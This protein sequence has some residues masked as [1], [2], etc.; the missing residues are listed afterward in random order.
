MGRVPQW[1]RDGS[2]ARE[3][4]PL[5]DGAPGAGSRGR[6][7]FA[8]LTAMSLLAAGVSLPI[9]TLAQP[10][11]AAVTVGSNISVF[12]D[13]DM[14]VATGYEVGEQLL[15]EVVRDGVVIGTTQGPAVETA[16]GAG[17]EVNHGPLGAPQPGDCW[18][19]FTPDIIGGDVIRVTPVD[20]PDA[21][22]D[23]MTVQD[24]AFTGDPVLEADG[25]VSVSGTATPG[26]DFAVEFRRDKPAPR[27]RR[28]PFVPAFEAG[29]NKWKATFRPSTT[30]SPEGLTTTQQRDIA[31]N[32][33]SWLAVA[34][35]ITETTLAE[36][37]EPGGVGAGC[38]G[39]ADPNSLVGGLEP[40]NI[41]SGDVTFSGTAKAGV[42]AVSVTVGALGARDAALVTDPNGGPST[43]TLTV[44]K[45]DLA[46][47]P[48]GN[49]SVTPKFDTLVGAARTVVKDTIA[50][51]AP[52]VSVPPGTYGAPQSVVLNKPTGETTS[53]VY[54]EIGNTAVPDPDQFSNL[55]TTQISVTS[56]QTLKGRLIDAAGNPGAVGTFDYKIGTP[57]AAPAGLTATEST[58][59]AGTANLRWTA[60]AGAT[61]YNV[62]RDS[63]KVNT[64][65]LTGTSTTDKPGPGDYSYVVRAV[66][67][68]GIESLDSNAATVTIAAPDVPTGLRATEGDTRVTLNWTAVAGAAKYRIYRD[69][70][71]LASEPA[72]NSF[73]NTGLTNGTLYEYA[74]SALD[75]GGNESPRT[76]VVQAVPQVPADTTPPP[77]PAVNPATGTYT[78]AQ[79][80]TASNTE[81]GAVQRFTITAGTTPPAD[82]TSADEVVPTAGIPVSATSTV[83]V[84]SFDAAGN[85][86]TVITRTY[87]ITT[88]PPADTTPP[89]ASTVNPPTGTYT[90]TQTVTATNTEAGVT[91]RYT[92]GVGTTVP[93]D[94]TTASPALP[95]GGLA[96]S[97]SSVVKVAAFDAA[98]NKSVVTRTY[99]I[100]PA[101]GTTRTVNVV[102]EADAMVK[103]ASP[104]TAFGTPTTL[105]SDGQELSTTGSAVHSYLRFN[106]TG[107]A[108]GETITGARLQVRTILN[109]GGTPNGPIVRRAANAASVTAAESLTWTGSTPTANTSNVGNFA[110]VANDVVA[111]TAV[112][113][114]TGNG[115]VTL[116][117]APES[118]DGLLFLDRTA[119]AA[120]D[121]PQLILTVSGGT[122]PPADTTP[123]PAPSVNPAT[124]TYTSA[125]TVTATNTEAGVT[126]R[127][128]VGNG[129][130][131]PADPTTAST[132]LPAGGLT[133][134]TS[135]VV[136]VAAFDA[137]GNRSTV[138]QRGY[139]ISAP[140]AGGTRTL[141]V[142]ASADTTVRQA[143]PTGTA[144]AATV[145][146]ADT[147]A[148]TGNAAT[149]E[150]SYVRFAIPAL[151]TG[152][153]ITGANLSLNVT[154]AT[155]DGPAI[156]RTATA[157]TEGTM[158]WNTGQP[159][160]SG[161]AAVGNYGAMALGR[162]STPVSGVTAAGTVS[163]QLYADGSDGVD[164][165]SRET[166][167]RP[168]LVLTIKTP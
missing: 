62:Y 139:I 50:P 134:S 42:A 35:K 69:G 47:L 13:R 150:T 144:G 84:A 83:K 6:R 138:V 52:T 1:S 111:S 156:W 59:A 38:T 99:T 133:V 154:N 146:N 131:V 136:K 80:V 152:E 87:T 132:A 19:G 2:T 93:A 11:G 60:A 96:V 18:N 66:E 110:T 32:E 5:T 116:Q 149:R 127:Y 109:N 85:R 159:A 103:E 72:T 89:P 15:V 118:T 55:Y 49:V 37:G 8:S 91:H 71:A 25:S 22:A 43:W 24:V 104:G 106:V 151:A 114:I 27:F 46:T 94:P 28:G 4:R 130:T 58:T 88:A 65:P 128:T 36:L 92:V 95:A 100:N 161:T 16:E 129:T 56:T 78:S 44:P 143:T 63:V 155:A 160:R 79:T 17:L 40:I 137:A 26:T 162:V 115:V 97:S 29:T 30:T 12:P 14:V 126:H 45:A 135:S 120:G 67:A 168:Q 53:K 101:T 157:W 33:A 142:D 102:A 74:V 158:T 51:L 166:T 77:A 148:T 108:A 107:L 90:G 34:D 75:A 39:S 31:L 122:T 23:T 98:G 140:P 164:I 112:S 54:W 121:K 105:V 57:P 86:S 48:E 167:T 153:S 10:A 3:R 70:T 9:L 7:S 64:A 119:A 141:V 145:L 76:G 165:S 125:Q 68:N 20:R 123:P 113:G 81:A 61:G 147:Q 124:G 21:V 73:I 117:L 163:F 82:P 41:A